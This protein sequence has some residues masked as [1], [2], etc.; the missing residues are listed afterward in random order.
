MAK[1]PVIPFSQGKEATLAASFFLLASSAILLTRL[2]GGVAL[3]WFANAP[4]II[5]LCK[6]GTLKRWRA[7]LMWTGPHL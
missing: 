7:P 4:L 2:N 6:Y 3:L 5:F 1:T